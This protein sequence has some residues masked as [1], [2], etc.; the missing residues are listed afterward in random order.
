[1]EAS[2]WAKISVKK[3]YSS[4]SSRGVTAT[5]SKPTVKS[6]EVAVKVTIDIPD[7]YFEVPELSARIVVPANAVNQKVITPS[8]EHNLSELISKQLGMNVHI[9]AT[10]EET[11]ET[12]KPKGKK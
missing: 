5:R 1:M 11:P 12:K 7:A 8:V 4:W 3:N 2:F 9:S 6:N 10:P